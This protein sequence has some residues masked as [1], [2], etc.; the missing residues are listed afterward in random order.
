MAGGIAPEKSF[1]VD[2][3]IRDAE[4][5]VV[6]GAPAVSAPRAEGGVAGGLAAIRVPN[7]R[8]Q[9]PDGRALMTSEGSFKMTDLRPESGI[10]QI[11]FRL[12]G[13]ADGLA[14]LLK[15][16]A[17]QPLASL[18]LDPAN[19][20]G[21]TD[22]RVN[23][24]L[25]IDA[26]PEFADLPLTISGGI[27]DI[28]V[29]KAFGR[30]K[31]EGANL[32]LAYNRGALNLRGEGRL[33]GTP[34]VIDLRRTAAAAGELTVLLTLDEAA[35]ARRGFSVGSQLTGPIALRIG[36]PVGAATVSSPRIEVDLAKAAID[37][38]IPGWTKPAG[39][40]GRVTFVLNEGNLADI[41][42]LSIDSGPV[43]IRGTAAFSQDGN[44]EKADISSLKFSPGDDLRAQ[45]ERNAGTYKVTV[46]GNV[47]DAR[48]FVKSF[49]GAPAA[50][51]ARER[52]REQ[53][54]VELVL[55][56]NNVT[57]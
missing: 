30:E 57:G 11:G 4:F 49:T 56:V 1:N 7:G 46:R 29:D 2:F 35:R 17:L 18:N 41:R 37:N 42:D 52:E 31:L 27:T 33:G 20:K 10:A 5:A 23:M 50:S 32:N 55:A 22:L 24:A 28:T 8:I 19:V 26:V 14:S 12:T 48:P 9:M 3:A 21:R 47:L 44:L 25:P 54:E 45:L 39:K 43:Q 40:P 53:R 6:E 15:E 36:I 38:L 34:A 51:S 13:G 16:P